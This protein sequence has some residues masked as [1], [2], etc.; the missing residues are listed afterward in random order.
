[1][2]NQNT[3][4]ILGC[5][6]M[7]IAYIF[8]ILE[9]ISKVNPRILEGIQHYVENS[10]LFITTED[11]WKF[12]LEKIRSH[13]GSHRTWLCLSLEYYKMGF[14]LHVFIGYIISIIVTQIIFTIW[15]Q[16]LKICLWRNHRWPIKIYNKSTREEQENVRTDP[17]PTI[18]TSS[19]SSIWGLI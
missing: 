16:S 17:F 14:W 12:D 13:Y 2:L 10:L 6:F 19:S 15:T 9:K 4:S 18:K 7:V 5:C 8:P 1:M 11:L 3:C